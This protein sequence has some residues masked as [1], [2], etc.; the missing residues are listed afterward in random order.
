MIV[1]VNGMCIGI[2]QPETDDATVTAT[3]LYTLHFTLYY[4]QL[5][6]AFTHS[7]LPFLLLYPFYYIC[8]KCDVLLQIKRWFIAT[9]AWK[10]YTLTGNWLIATII[11]LEQIPINLFY[12][13]GCVHL[14]MLRICNGKQISLNMKYTLKH[15]CW[16]CCRY[17][18]T[19][20]QLYFK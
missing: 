11:I 3:A 6:S 1:F 17:V 12:W 13:F 19:Y 7:P 5:V 10:C 15:Y 18:D 4:S 2:L 20:F 14:R 8:R 16:L 9:V